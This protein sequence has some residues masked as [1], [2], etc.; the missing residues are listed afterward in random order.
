MNLAFK[1]LL[2]H[3]YTSTFAVYH[4]I[5]YRCARGFKSADFLPGNLVRQSQL[6]PPKKKENRPRNVSIWIR[7]FASSAIFAPAQILRRVN[8][9]V[10]VRQIITTVHCSQINSARFFFCNIGGHCH[11]PI[12]ANCACKLKR[13]PFKYSP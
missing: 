7:V 1:S 12:N 9:T 6:P 13:Q 8:Y 5:G 3:L 4:C 10:H 11:R 2:R